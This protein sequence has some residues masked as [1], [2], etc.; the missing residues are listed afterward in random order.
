M[1]T[2]EQNLYGRL[3]IKHFPLFSSMHSDP[4]IPPAPAVPRDAGPE[5]PS[6]SEAQRRHFPAQPAWYQPVY[7]TQPVSQLSSSSN[8]VAVYMHDRSVATA[9]CKRS[10][11]IVCYRDGTFSE[12]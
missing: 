3:N 5:P 12:R 1:S 11:I 2:E 9:A 10:N 6:D 8:T 7:A 4:C